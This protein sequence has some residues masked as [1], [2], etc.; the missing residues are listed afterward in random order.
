MHY[1]IVIKKNDGFVNESSPISFKSIDFGMADAIN[2]DYLLTNGFLDTDGY[3]SK[4]IDG[5]KFF[6]IG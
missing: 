6:V 2:E 4:I 5:N 3:I 1:R